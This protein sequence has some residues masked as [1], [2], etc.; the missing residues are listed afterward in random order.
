MGAPEFVNVEIPRDRFGRPMLMPATGRS[1]KR[2]PYRRCTTF[3]GVLE[4][5]S[6]LMRWGQRQVALGMGQRPDLVMAAAAADPGDK[7]TIGGIAERAA[8]A[9]K[10]IQGDAASIG[11][12]LHAFTERMDRGDTIGHVPAEY[13]ADLDAYWA[14]TK[15]ITWQAIETF[16]CHDDWLVAGTA[17]RIGTVGGGRPA[18][19]DVKTGGIDY[20][21]LKMSMQLAMY[22]RMTAYDIATDTRV[23][24]TEPVDVNYGYIIH[25]PAGQGRCDVYETHIGEA[26]G[27][28]LVAKQV[29][30]CRERK[31]LLTPYREPNPVATW[32]S[33]IANANSLERLR[34]IWQ[35]AKELGQLTP[36]LKA[37]LTA[38]SQELAA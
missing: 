31:N 30:G 1:K 16:R 32:E 19:Y 14:A 12:A 38:R 36:Q 27:A 23:A 15:H 28:C 13:R 10:G 33:L 22:A 6:A 2:I 3:V 20:G 17:D 21:Q 18:I 35:R 29:W 37:L 7:A 24:D 4:E 26:W 8:E 5:T 25:L 9:A 11:T 34:E